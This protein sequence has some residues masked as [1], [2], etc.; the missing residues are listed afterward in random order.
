[1]VVGQVR[2]AHGIWLTQFN[3]DKIDE[4]IVGVTQRNWK[5][6]TLTGILLASMLCM[7]IA[8]DILHI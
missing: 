6:K 5:A 1:M 8:N 2:I 4:I 7:Y 3:G